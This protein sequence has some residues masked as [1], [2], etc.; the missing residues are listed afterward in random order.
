VSTLHI[1]LDEDTDAA[2]T[3]LAKSCGTAPADLAA[4]I[5]AA[6]LGEQGRTASPEAPTWPTSV[7][8]SEVLRVVQEKEAYL[9]SGGSERPDPI[10]ALVGKYRGDRVNDIDEV[11]YGQ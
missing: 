7:P 11:V 5:V 8:V 2:L 10:D 6:Y 1:Q 9:H 4:K 3:A